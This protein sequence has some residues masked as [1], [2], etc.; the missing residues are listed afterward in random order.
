MASLDSL[1]AREVLDSRG[2]PTIEV[3]A[4]ADS[5]VRGRAIAAT[6]GSVGRHEARELRDVEHARHGGRGVLKAVRQV[7]SEVALALRGMDLDDQTAIDRALIALDGT[8]DKARLGSQ[9]TLAVSM[10]TAQAAAA[11]R[12]EPLYIHLNRLWKERLGPL[13]AAEPTLPMPMAHMIRGLTRSGRSLDF[14]DVLMIPVGARDF[15]EAV[16]MISAVHRALGEVLSRHGHPAHLTASHGG[17]GPKL[18]SNSQAVDHVL[19]AVIAAGLTISR[20]VAVALDVA[21]EHIQ[22]P[23][24]HIYHL[25]LGGDSHDSSAMIAMLE[26]WVR[27]YPIVSIEDGLGQDDWGGWIILTGRLGATVQL[28]GDDLFATRV[29][30]I[31]EGF[32]QGVANAVVIKPGQVGTLSE[33]LD[34]LALARRK[35]GRAIVAARTG[36]TEDSAIADLAV[37]T[38][39]GQVKFGAMI[40]S[41]R[42]TK[43]NRLLRIEADLGTQA[44]FPGR[45]ALTEIPNG[46]IH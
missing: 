3:E 8:P 18:W 10:A 4:V 7:A 24:T 28:V 32:D 9:A 27:Q 20:D 14:Q 35:G 12:N 37:A 6:G 45:S 25:A 13:Q 11:C 31:S 36:E 46:L 39:A 40:G 30:R 22:D 43:Y 41:E 21:A 19:D 42:L 15:S 26:H 1:I 23:K 34:A 33:T 17:Y 38:G 2:H 16:L 5:G 44:H 29:D